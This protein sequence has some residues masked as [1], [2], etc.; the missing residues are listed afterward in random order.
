VQTVDEVSGFS[1]NVER[2]P[3]QA[4]W[5]DRALL[6]ARDLSLK[7][8]ITRMRGGRLDAVKPGAPGFGAYKPSGWRCGE[9]CPWGKP[10]GSAS[11]LNSL[12]KPHW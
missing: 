3:A 6:L 11:L 12:P 1:R 4:I 5:S 7:A 10:P 2:V 8:L 9:F